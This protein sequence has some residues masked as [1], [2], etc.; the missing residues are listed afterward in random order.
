MFYRLRQLY[1]ALRPKIKEEELTWLRGVLT[2]Q[3]LSLFDKQLLIEKR[4][5]IDVASEVLCQKSDVVLNLGETAFNNLL[6]AAFL[7]DCGKSL[8]SLRLWQRVFIVCY[9]YLPQRTKKSITSRQRSIFSKTI[10]IYHQH[11][12]WGKHLAAKTGLNQE[13]QAL[14][15]NHHSPNNQIEQILFEA[16][17]KH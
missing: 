3:E 16:D 14:I 12:C 10:V 2:E 8:I 11:P 17:N 15:E 1:K 13:V 4:H 6:K 9:N 5:A 7:H